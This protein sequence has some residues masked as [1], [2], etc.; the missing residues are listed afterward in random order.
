[1][2]VTY[3]VITIINSSLNVFASEKKPDTFIKFNKIQ[4][5]ILV[6]ASSPSYLTCQQNHIKIV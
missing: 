6:T 4:C 2:T 3:H 5:R 1:M